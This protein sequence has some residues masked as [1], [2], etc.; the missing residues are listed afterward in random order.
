VE[1]KIINN[2]IEREWVRIGFVEGHGT[3]TEIQNYQF[4][5]NIIK[6]RAAS[7]CYRLKQIDFLGS[8]EYSDEVLVANPAPV[9]YALQQNFPN[10][11]NPITTISISLPIKSQVEIVIYNTLGEKVNQLVKEEIEAGSYTVKFDATTLSSGIYFYRLQALPTGRQ[12]GS[13]VE[14]K[15]MVLMK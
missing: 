5:D 8:Y 10:P 15:K 7:L 4:I 9:D 13:F 2:D 11:F 12:A 1:R 6:I 3:T 14:T